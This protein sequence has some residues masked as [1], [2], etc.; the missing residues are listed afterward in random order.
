MIYRK[1]LSVAITAAKLIK[2]K[3]IIRFHSQ[4]ALF[5]FMEDIK[6]PFLAKSFSRKK[7]PKQPAYMPVNYIPSI[8]FLIKQGI[9][10]RQKGSYRIAFEVNK[11]NLDNYLKTYKK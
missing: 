6:N 8:D 1:N 4:N 3:R 9:L 2:Q 10:S 11:Q 5:I 7:K